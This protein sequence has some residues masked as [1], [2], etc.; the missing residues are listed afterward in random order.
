MK[1]SRLRIVYIVALVVLGVLLVFTVLR[2]MAIG[3]EYSEV[4]QE[5]LLQTEDEWIIQFNIINH[6]GK[7]TAYSIEVIAGD[8]KY[9]EDIRVLDGRIFTYI[10]HIRRSSAEEVSFSIYKE[11]EDTPVEKIIYHF[12]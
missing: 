7:D 4:Q 10:H 8:K 3:I 2:P 6:E 12:E 5:K 11:S 9:V 1:V